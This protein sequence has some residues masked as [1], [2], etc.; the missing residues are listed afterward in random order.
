M[1]MAT[2]HQQTSYDLERLLAETGQQNRQAF[3]ALYQ[4][5]SS[6]LFAVLIRIL[7]NRD[8]AADVLQEVY[9]TIWRRAAQF[10]PA[11]GK[12]LSWMAIVTRNAG[13]DALRRRRPNH[14]SDDNCKALAFEGPCAFEAIKGSDARAIILR[15]LSSLSPNMREA[16]RL[17]Y[18]EER[19]LTEVAEA[20]QSPLNTTKSWIRR[21]LQ[22]L[23]SEMSDQCLNNL[24]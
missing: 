24:I 3:T 1:E 23:R 10:D 19:A 8:E 14:V 13:I 12:A 2:L 6:K 11:K 18:L 20:M 4:Q 7:R 17:Y 9:I 15:N 5:T 16:I 22:N 21:G